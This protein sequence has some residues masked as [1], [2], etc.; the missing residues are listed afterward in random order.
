MERSFFNPNK[1]KTSKNL[2]LIPFLSDKKILKLIEDQAIGKRRILSSVLFSYADY[3]VLYG[4]LGYS[5]L[6]TVIEFIKNVRDKNIFFLGTAGSLNKAINYPELLN[7]YE[8]YP[9]GIFNHFTDKKSLF[10]KKA[11]EVSLSDV[12]GISVD[13]IQR[14]N[15]TWYE[16]VKNCNLDVVDMEIFPLRWYFGVEFTAFVV[17]SDMVSDTGIFT[18]NREKVKEKMFQ[19]YNEIIGMIK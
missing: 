10:L 18:F 9:G 19:G 1:I 14:E 12:K 8:T 15:L 3:D 7:V 11:G 13:I 5:N 17:T 4:F 16:S 2:I 6:L